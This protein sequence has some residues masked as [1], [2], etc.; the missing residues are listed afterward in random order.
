MVIIFAFVEADT[1][2][3]ALHN[4]YEIAGGVFRRQKAGACAGGAGHALDLP[5]VFTAVGIYADV[6]ALARVPSC[7]VGL[8]TWHSRMRQHHNGR[9]QKFVAEKENAG[10]ARVFLCAVATVKIEKNPSYDSS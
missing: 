1:H 3:Q 9:C 10:V 6:H 8:F 5:V 2:R 4:F 7:A